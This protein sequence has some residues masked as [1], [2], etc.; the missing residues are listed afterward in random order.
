MIQKQKL[1]VIC[2][3]TA[4]GKS[5]LAVELALQMNGEVISADSRQIYR[6]LNIGSG[7]ITM[8]EMRGIP[9][10]LLDIADPSQSISVV[11]YKQLADAAIADIAA[12]GKLPILC[13]GTGLYI[14]AVV[15]NRTFPQVPPNPELRAEL[16]KL[17]LEELKT[18]LEE[19]DPDRFETVDQNNPMRLVR[20]IEIV[21]ALGS[22]PPESRNESPYDVTMIGLELPKE[23]LVQRIQARLEKRLE[24]GM[25]EEVKNLHG[26]GVSWERLEALGLEYRYLA[27][28]LQEKISY[29][30]MK[31]LIATKS[32][33]YAR[34]QMVWFKRDERI[35]WM[36]PDKLLPE[37]LSQKLIQSLR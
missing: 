4:T 28:Y 20:A 19:L 10:H 14:S 37:L 33:Q 27:Q 12:R 2:G 31:E 30:E 1:L 23:E 9:H 5:D 25:I 26:Q 16:E 32:W 11:E 7:K 13:G 35:R 22:V 29:D 18:K 15:D 17:S 24:T 8:D 21:M 34:R 6:G 3:P 36:N